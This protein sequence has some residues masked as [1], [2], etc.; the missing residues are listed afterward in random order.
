MLL[1]HALTLARSVVTA[2]LLSPDDF[3]LFSMA[4]T[5]VTALGALTSVSL[6]HAITARDLDAGGER[7]RTQL[8]AT[9]TA[10]LLRRLL[11]TLM[12]AA[13][14]YPAARFYGRA[15]LM[16][17]LPC[18]A[19]LPLTQGLQNVGLAILRNRIS[20]ARLFWHET[21]S[22]FVSAVVSVALAVAFRNVWALVFGQLAG[23]AAGTAFSYLLH[24]YRPRLVFDR[25]LFRQA[26]HFGKYATVIGGL[27]YVTTTA[28]NVLVGRLFG[29]GVLGVYAV[30]YGLASLPA[31]VVMGAVGRAMFPAYAG[32]AARGLRRVAPAFNR[33]LA[34][35]SALLVLVTVPLFLLAPEVVSVLYG[36]KWEAAGG[37]LRVLSLVG[38]MRGLV[39]IISWLHM[40]L[41]RPREAA[42][43]KVVEAVVFL[44]LLYPLTSL[45]GVKGAA[46]TGVA[47][48]LVGLC[49]RLLSIRRLIP[50]AFGRAVLIVLASFAS[51]AGGAGAGWLTLKA[52]EGDWARLA[53]GGAVSTV[54]TAVLLH[55][56]T[57]GLRAEVRATVRALR[58]RAGF[59]KAG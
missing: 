31:G 10:E 20:F 22:A 17:I 9:W 45:Y 59:L 19:L 50:L 5:A 54:L 32:L 27:A 1:T 12:L 53:A 46:Y 51:G 29:A 40:G 47:A 18:A 33:S 23:A 28:D 11:V 58:P 15:E 3:G 36:R 34:A 39:V 6:D 16:L 21:A 7:L 14:V 49:N 56:L 26:F 48:Y 30:A 25:E 2:R 42:A 24:P 55:R 13:L 8:D 43:G 38:L 37:V 44:A 4:L 57:P 35:G 52:V 41:G